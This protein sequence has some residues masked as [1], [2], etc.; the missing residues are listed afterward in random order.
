MPLKRTP[1]ATPSPCPSVAPTIGDTVAGTS[2]SELGV[3]GSSRQNSLART[4]LTD[5]VPEFHGSAPDLSS[6]TLAERKKRKHDGENEDFLSV[7][8]MFATLTKSMSEL[9][10]SVS[11]IKLQNTELTKSVEII[12]QKNDDFLK[13]IAMLEQERVEDKKRIYQLEDKL[14]LLERK[15][16][17]TGI[18]IRN[19]QKTNGE[20]KDD[21]CSIAKTLGQT[22]NMEIGKSDIKD[23]Y[24]INSKDTSQPIIVEFTSALTKE[25]LLKEL[26]SFNKTKPKGDKLN[27]SHLGLTQPLKP[28][29]VSE[30]LTSRAQRLFYLARSH[31]KQYGYSFCWTLNGLVYLRK[32]ENS[33]HLKISSEDCLESLR[34]NE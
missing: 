31:Q 14:E 1:P 8:Q 7:K 19:I 10:S 23:I 11:V 20:S 26:K 13:K 24:R 29:Y 18:E 9:Q 2:D 17:A 27:T 3:R 22:I 15:S 21:L 5:S 4:F 12:S 16:R 34:R 33:T 28:V 25:K 6:K 32:D 30:T